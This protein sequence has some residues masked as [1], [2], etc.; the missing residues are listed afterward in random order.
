[1]GRRHV[2]ARTAFRQGRDAAPAPHAPGCAPQH[3]CIQTPSSRSET[4]ID[5]SRR[6]HTCMCST[7]PLHHPSNVYTQGRMVPRWRTHLGSAILLLLGEVEVFLERLSVDS[8]KGCNSCLASVCH[9]CKWRS[10]RLSR[11]SLSGTTL[12]ITRASL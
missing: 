8:G 12:H 10:K 6:Q 9:A 5:T 3:H 11:K 1:M 7:Q 2:R 4:R